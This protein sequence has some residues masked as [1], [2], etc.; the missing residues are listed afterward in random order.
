[1][2]AKVH[3]KADR[4]SSSSTRFVEY[5]KAHRGVLCMLLSNKLAG[6]AVNVS[7]LF[8]ESVGL[9]SQTIARARVSYLTELQ[10]VWLRSVCA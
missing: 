10:R 5:A 2:R 1:M 7:D 9:A 6:S 8:G 3:N 4:G